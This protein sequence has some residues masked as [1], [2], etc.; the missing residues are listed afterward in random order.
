MVTSKRLPEDV[1]RLFDGAGG[2]GCAAQ[3]LSIMKSWT[4]PLYRT[5]VVRTPAAVKLRA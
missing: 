5:L 3:G 4:M 1:D 2:R